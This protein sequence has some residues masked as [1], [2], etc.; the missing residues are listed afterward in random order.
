MKPFDECDGLDL[1]ALVSSGKASPQE[2]LREAVSRACAVRDVLNPL[3]Q[4]FPER[5]ELAIS[6]GLP[7][8]PFRGVPFLLKDMATLAGTPTW[9]AMSLRRKG[10]PR[11]G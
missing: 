4:L 7:V 9:V 8:G 3:S 10:T 11:K 5:A 2:L 1:A 6:R